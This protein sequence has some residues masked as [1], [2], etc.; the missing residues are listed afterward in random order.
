MILEINSLSIT[1][2]ICGN[3]YVCSHNLNLNVESDVRVYDELK[4]ESEI[5]T[6]LK[7]YGYRGIY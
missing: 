2:E 3:K 6:T 1:E 7:R 5:N 4:E